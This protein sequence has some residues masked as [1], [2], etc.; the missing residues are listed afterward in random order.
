[1]VCNYFPFIPS[2]GVVDVDVLVTVPGKGRGFRILLQLSSSLQ[3]ALLMSSVWTEQYV[4]AEFI[5][6]T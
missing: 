2:S 4:T 6:N 1:M 5:P 3:Q